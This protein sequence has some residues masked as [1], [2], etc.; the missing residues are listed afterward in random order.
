MFGSSEPEEASL[1]TVLGVEPEATDEEL[2]AAYRRLA[3]RLH[4][5]RNGGDTERFQAVQ[6]AYETLADPAKRMV[7]DRFGQTGLGFLDQFAGDG[8]DGG[9]R[10]QQVAIVLRLIAFFTGPGFFWVT[11][12]VCMQCCDWHWRQR[13]T[14]GVV[15]LAA[16]GTA[17]RLDVRCDAQVRV[18][19]GAQP[20]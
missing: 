10:A 9:A 7:Y 18:F 19:R 11:L 8:D 6:G 2:Q 16:H 20:V 14:R 4:P 12:V 15:V 13:L 1:Y 5:D 17:V 3:R